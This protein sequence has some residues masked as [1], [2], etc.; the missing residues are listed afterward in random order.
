MIMM[1]LNILSVRLP[2]GHCRRSERSSKSG[3]IARRYSGFK[4]QE[5]HF[6]TE[7]MG[8]LVQKYIL[9]IFPCLFSGQI[10][11]EIA[12]VSLQAIVL[13]WYS[14]CQ[15]GFLA[16]KIRLSIFACSPQFF[17]RGELGLLRLAL[18]A[19]FGLIQRDEVFLALETDFGNIFFQELKFSISFHAELDAVSAMPAG[20]LSHYLEA[21]NLPP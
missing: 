5:P 10:I 19:P 2:F 8:S 6:V 18:I 14:H 13:G 16:R 11:A 20:L 12:F 1:P 3:A 21:H 4:L 7:N 15:L 17:S 9:G